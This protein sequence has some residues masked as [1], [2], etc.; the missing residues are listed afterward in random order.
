M[1]LLSVKLE[2]I[3]LIDCGQY[4]IRFGSVKSFPSY[5]P[6]L[7]LQDSFLLGKHE[8]CQISKEIF[9]GLM[10]WDTGKKW[11]MGRER[12]LREVLGPVLDPWRREELLKQ[13]ISIQEGGESKITLS[14]VRENFHEVKFS[15]I[16]DLKLRRLSFWSHLEMID[17]VS[18]DRAISF[19]VCLITQLVGV[20]PDIKETKKIF[21]RIQ[22]GVNT[23]RRS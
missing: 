2:D 1:S 6:F 20:G 9:G 21:T 14:L 8:I 22:D 3:L 5:R 18:R 23:Y 12:F 15:N 4:I 10:E 17:I 16:T 7:I 13:V 11:N 19:A